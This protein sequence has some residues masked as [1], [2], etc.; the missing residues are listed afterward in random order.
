[1]TLLLTKGQITFQ[2][3]NDDMNFLRYVSKKTGSSLSSIYRDNTLIDFRAWK[4]AFLL[5]EYNTG[6]IGFKKLCTLGAISF[7]DGMNLLESEKIEPPIPEFVND[8]TLKIAKNIT[9]EELFKTGKMKRKTP[10]IEFN[11]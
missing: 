3:S 7:S 11:D 2:L 8:Y 6:R 10:E 9:S 1:M 5:K 4:I